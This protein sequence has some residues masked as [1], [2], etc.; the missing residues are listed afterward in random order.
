M[1]ITYPNYTNR[2]SIVSPW[3]IFGGWL[4]FGGGLIFGRL[5]ELVYRGAYIG[6]GLYSGFYGML[7]QEWNY[8]W[9]SSVKLK[10][11]VCENKNFPTIL[12]QR[13]CL[14]TV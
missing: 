14:V 1:F 5:F 3:V 12:S 7:K 13:S 8:N 6:E 9:S 11:E 10:L 2:I 4:V